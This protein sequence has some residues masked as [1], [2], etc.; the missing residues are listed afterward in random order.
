MIDEVQVNDLAL[1]H[2]AELAFSRGLTVL[3]GE[4]GT[5]KTALLLALK[6]LMGARADKG[7]VR[8]GADGLRVSGRFCDVSW[9]QEAVVCRR[10]SAD[11]RSRATIDGDMVSMRELSELVGG[12]VDLCGQFEHQQLMRPATH[13]SLLD[14]WA[15]LDVSQARCAY[16][17]ALAYARSCAADLARVEEAARTS[18]AKLDEARFVLKRIGEVDPQEGEYEELMRSLARAE[19]AEALF[20][21]VESAR[22]ALS[23]DQGALEALD[24]AAT[25]LEQSAS[26]D[27]ALGKLA[28]S[29]REAGYVIEDVAADVRRYREQ[30]EFDPDQLIEQQDRFAQLQGL[31]RAFGPT[32]DQVMGAFAEAREAVSLVDDADARRRAARAAL[33]DA[34]CALSECADALD[35]ARAKAAPAFSQAVTAVM[36]RLEMGGAELVCSIERLD[37][38]QWTAQGPSSVEFLYRPSAG[39]TARPLARIASGGEVSRV[40]LAIKVALGAADA[41]ETLVFDEVDAG[42]GGATAVALAEVIADLACTHQVIVVTHLAQVA[43]HADAHYVVRRVDAF[44]GASEKEASAPDASFVPETTIT[45]LAPDER[46]YEIARML[47]GDAT[48]A[49]IAHARE[50]L[51]AT[52]PA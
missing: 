15:G 42:V 50:M 41:V 39:M 17:Q 12:S 5:G 14:A 4:T 3:T 1:I 34:E 10:V 31:V 25:A 28:A 13:A 21:A 33:D 8:E 32:M 46:P 9:G 29:L 49:S 7:M 24:Q 43:V 2:E 30:V 19:H 11:G 35:A 16:E 37:R 23:G 47:S 51:A 36:A 52:S 26:F 20:A 22:T 6:L 27:E 18:A 40:M 44:G 48:E 38:A 45:L